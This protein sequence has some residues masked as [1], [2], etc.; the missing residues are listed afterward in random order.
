MTVMQLSPLPP[1][2][3]VIGF[4]DFL[5]LSDFIDSEASVVIPLRMTNYVSGEINLATEFSFF[6]FPPID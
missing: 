3:A 1:S 6:P 4:S 2:Q 5:G